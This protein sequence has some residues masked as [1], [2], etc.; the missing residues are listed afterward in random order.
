[1]YT[2]FLNTLFTLYFKYLIWNN[3]IG[4]KYALNL[5]SLEFQ[6][7]YLC[8]NG[9]TFKISAITF[10][11]MFMQQLRRFN[12]TILRKYFLLILPTINIIQT[13]FD[14]HYF[15]FPEDFF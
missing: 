9:I 15:R 7:Q 2:D 8:N 11:N 10:R 6:Y 3:T 1:M 5:F 4:K 12:T 14:A 13:T